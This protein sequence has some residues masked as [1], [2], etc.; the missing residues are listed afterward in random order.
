MPKKKAECNYSVLSFRI[1]MW[2]SA[3]IM[4]KYA[5]F[6]VHLYLKGLEQAYIKIYQWH[7]KLKENNLLAQKIEWPGRG[8][9]GTINS[10]G[11]FFPFLEEY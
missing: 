8:N 9:C 1:H 7:R 11:F 5:A 10:R 6:C 2:K 3:C 4:K